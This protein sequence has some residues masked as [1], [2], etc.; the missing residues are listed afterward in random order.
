MDG[1]TERI[2]Q[3]LRCPQCR[4]ALSAVGFERGEAYQGFYCRACSLSFPSLDGVLRILVPPAQRDPV[5]ESFGFQWQARAAG[6]FEKD[7]LYGLTK[8]QEFSAFFNAYDIYPSDLKG[9]MVLDAGCGDG[10]LLQLLSGFGAEIVGMDINAS[11]ACGHCGLPDVLV[12]QADIFR[13][14]FQPNCFDFVWCEGVI[15]HTPDPEKAFRS[16]SQLVKPGGRLYL[17]VY[18]SDRL[19]IYQ[20]IRDIL[21]KPYVVPRRALVALCYLLAVAALPAFRITGRKRSL[22][23][24]AF[25]LFDNLSPRY[26]W[27]YQEEDIRHWFKEASFEDL[28]ITGHIG[29]SGRRVA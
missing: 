8:E 9:K 14:C 20:R 29:M 26:Q 19:T 10:T 18:P 13:P 23:T 3:A 2:R 16:V 24:I 27:R 5:A 22:R 6:T 12:L 15:V 25:D 21:R 7:T 1:V 17:W 11:I 4:G 28:R